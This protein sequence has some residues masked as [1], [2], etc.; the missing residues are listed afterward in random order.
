MRVNANDGYNHDQRFSATYT[1]M[2]RQGRM[3]P[4]TWRAG[5]SPQGPAKD[6]ARVNIV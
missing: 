5:L 1:A 4:P 6:E 3:T 2:V